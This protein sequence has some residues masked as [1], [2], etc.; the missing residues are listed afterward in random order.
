MAQKRLVRGASRGSRKDGPVSSVAL[1]AD[2]LTIDAGIALGSFAAEQYLNLAVRLEERMTSES[3]S[4]YLL[5]V[6]S[7]EPAAG[8]TLTS[9][10]LALTFGRMSDKRVLLI[11]CDM[12][13]PSLAG[14]LEGVITGRG[15]ADILVDHA[16]LSNTVRAVRNT[17]LDLLEAGTVSKVENLIADHRMVD[18]IAQARSQYDLVIFDSPPLPLASG[19]SLANLAQGVLLVVRAGQTKRKDIESAL[20]TFQPGKVVGLMLNGVRRRGLSS[21]AYGSYVYY[22]NPRTSAADRSKARGR[23]GGEVPP[24]PRELS[25]DDRSG[26]GKGT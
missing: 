4:A 3:E 25:L 12:R 1:K 16:D 8:K 21:S 14:Y 11:E 26:S 19:R 6:T 9:L 15:L 10:N 22:D 20:S 13:R 5:A 17:G 23:T 24:Y 18:L 7:P 2:S